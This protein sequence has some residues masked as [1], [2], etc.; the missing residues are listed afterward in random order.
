M[1]EAVV[2]LVGEALLLSL[3]LA[4]PVL[5]AALAAGILTGLLGAVTQ[6]QE[7]SVALVIRLAAMAASLVVFAP[8]LARQL[9]AFGREVMVMV[10]R[11]GGAR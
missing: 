4:L 3:W 6:V 11:V 8:L 10:E 7:A 5:V 2:S 1:I 9:V